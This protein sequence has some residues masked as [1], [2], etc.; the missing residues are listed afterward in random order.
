[1]AEDPMAD[2][3]EPRADLGRERR[4]VDP[5]GGM[6]AEPVTLSNEAVGGRDTGSVSGA[7]VRV[8]LDA[9]GTWRFWWTALTL[10]ALGWFVLFVLRDGGNLLYLL[11]VSWFAS[12]AMEPAVRWL[13]QRMRRGLAT[14]VVMVGVVVFLVL[15]FAA[16]GR[17]FVDQVAQLVRTLPDLVQQTLDTVNRRLSTN[18][19]VND[20][21]AALNLTPEKVAAYANEVLG[22]V[23]GLFGSIASTVFSM[24]TFGM[25]TF[26]FS[27][28]GPRLR[29]W[30][31]RR[32]P[33]SQQSLFAT[34]WDLTT[35]KTG[36]YVAARVT[37]AAV[38]AAASSIVFALIGLPS[39]FALGLWT[40]VVAQFIPT[41]GTYISIALPVL[42]GLM[43]PEP[44]TGVA[45]LA[46][47]IAYQQVENLTL[48]PRIS[49]R[50]VNVHPAVAFASVL[51]GTSLFG[52]AGA[53]LAVPVSAMLLAL[54]D[55]EVLRRRPVPNDDDDD[56][57]PAEQDLA[58]TPDGPTR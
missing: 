29:Q 56:D 10:V 18:Y 5:P 2:E 43:S 39:W 35:I 58:V 16:F 27:A 44:W 42:V 3:A 19:S 23:L 38:N 22:G 51:L 13:S 36:G 46:W 12:L 15:F 8:V 52:V 21:I 37:L 11:I 7:P 50:A 28:D 25:F 1:M 54:F 53:L 33:A 6:P 24:V 57:E 40:G 20:A 4:V 30:I 45:A 17:L 55:L 26:Y 48:E 9:R 47:G 49:A 32:L 41:I 34:A 14:I 31:A